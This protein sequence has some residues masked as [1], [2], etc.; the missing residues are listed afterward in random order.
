MVVALTGATVFD[1]DRL[2]DGRAVVVDGATILAVRAE[3]D[4]PAG[5]ERVAIEG[6][7]R[8][9][10]HRHPGEWRRR[11]PVQR[12]ARASTRS[13]RS[14][15][16]T[17][18][19]ARPAFSPPSSVT[20]QRRCARPLKPCAPRSRA[21]TPGLLGV[22]FEG[23]WLSPARKGAH[24]E[25]F[26]RDF[27]EAD[28]ALLTAPGLGRVH[29]TLAP[30]RVPRGHDRAARR[31][32]RRRLGRPYR[33]RSSRRCGRR[34][35]PGSP[36]TRI[37][38]TPCRRSPAAR[39][40]R[41]A[42]RSTIRTLLRPD[43]RSRACQ[44]RRAS[45]IAIA[46]AWLGAHDAR[47]RRDADGRHR[48]DRLRSLRPADREARRPAGQPRPARSPAPIST[49]RPPSATPPRRSACRSRPRCRWP[50]ACRPNFWGS[51]TLGRIAPGCRADLVLLDDGLR[52]VDTW[53]GGKRSG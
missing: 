47:H 38:S 3:T 17:G 52:V 41:S 36:A 44:R 16:R 9:G 46:R 25:R 7:A 14:A 29:V 10:L 49:W 40:A 33:G 26:L 18:V 53:I 42:R 34:G 35:R 19:S 4:L 27:T 32:G 2:A 24:D 1:G 30:E 28:F 6:P 15:Q 51:T 48:R 50:R 8:A 31:G 43:R 5:I 13:P 21:G 22:H 37:S 12:C 45:A 23:P 39:P 11:R 20:R